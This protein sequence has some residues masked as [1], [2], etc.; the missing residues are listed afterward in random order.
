MEFNFKENEIIILSGP[1]GT[2]KSTFAKEKFPQSILNSDQFRQ[3]VGNQTEVNE[4]PDDVSYDND[5]GRLKLIEKRRFG[6][7]SEAAFEALR[8]VLEARAKLGLQSVIDATNLHIDDIRAYSEIAQKTH[9]PISIIFFNIPLR[10]AIKMNEQHINGTNEKRL[11]FQFKNVRDLLKNKK[12]LDQ[13]GINNIYEVDNIEFSDIQINIKKP[14]FIIDI[15]KGLD[16]MGDGHGLLESRINLMEKAGYIKGKDGVYRHPEG[17]KLVYLNDETGKGSQ[18]YEKAEYGKYPSIAM[19][20]MMMKQVKAGEAYAVDS[21]HNYKLWRYLEGRNVQMTNG[22]ELVVEEFEKFKEE[23]GEEKTAELKQELH[24]FLKWLP[25]H[26]IIEDQGIRRAVVVHAGIKDDMIGKNSFEVKDFCRFGPTDGDKEDGTPNRLDWTQDH[27]NG[28]LVIW[29]HDPKPDHEIIHDTINIDQGGFCGHYLT[30]MRYPEMEFIKEKVNECFVS[31]EKNPIKKYQANRFEAPTLQKYTD[32]FEVITS[33]GKV[34]V[35]GRYAKDAIETISTRTVRM[36]ELIYVAPTMSPTPETS[37]LDDYLEHPNEAFGYYKSKGIKQVVVQKKHM[38]SR[39]LVTLFKDKQTGKKYFNKETLGTVASRNNI[40]FFDG[41]DETKVIEKLVNDLTKAEFFTK[42]NTDMVVMDCEILPWNLKAAG[43]IKKQYGLTSNTATYARQKHYE[44]L[45]E[46]YGDNEEGQGVIGEAARKAVN[47]I[48]F[49]DAFSNYCWDTNDLEGIQIAP[50]HILAFSEKSNFDMSH[51]WHMDISKEMSLMSSL[52]I[53][54]PY[55]I[56][57]LDNQD[58][59]DDATSWWAKTTEDGH[60][61]FVIKPYNFVEVDQ[62]ENVIQP[63]IKVRGREYL[64][65]IYGM[66]YLEPENLVVLKKR[67]AH[68]KMRNAIKQF[69]LSI[70]SINRFVKMDRMD[71]VHECILA[72]LSVDSDIV[73][74][75]L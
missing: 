35:D 57:N 19:A 73:D 54:T 10:D 68:K 59:I 24:K 39:A 46:F 47:A 37:N 20:V 41:Q 62:W 31:D 64:R 4:V 12:R 1:T 22:D 52:V 16:I 53:E 51:K 49:H 60:E 9:V 17:R 25:S 40:R 2:G 48:K 65:I 5:K 34:E 28:M 63:A 21:N 14:N 43:L 44:V 7:V 30:L 8:H 15:E 13:I 26:L 67:S 42:H 58:E 66:D 71:R 55:K 38:G 29:G 56:I 23:Y 27:N 36:E 69:V 70:E 18:S 61:G 75:R 45:K 32:K 74:P 6:A 72:S 33:H 50:F 3:M 11:K